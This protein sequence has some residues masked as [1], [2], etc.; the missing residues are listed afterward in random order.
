ML[1]H[2][3]IH[4]RMLGQARKTYLWKCKDI[5]VNTKDSLTGAAGGES[6]KPGEDDP[7]RSYFESLDFDVVKA[8]RK[9][10]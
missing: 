8:G 6:H 2:T 4:E 10:Y 7:H 9:S 3:T 1:S 5:I